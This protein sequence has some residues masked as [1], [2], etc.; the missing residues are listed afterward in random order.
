MPQNEGLSPVNQSEQIKHHLQT[1]LVQI[2]AVNIGKHQDYQPPLATGA[3]GRFTDSPDT[4]QETRNTKQQ[5]ERRDPELEDSSREQQNQPRS[6]QRAEH[7]STHSQAL[8]MFLTGESSHLST[9]LKVQGTERGGSIIGLGFVWECQGIS[10]SPFYLCES[11]KEMIIH[12]KICEHMRSY[13]HQLQYIVSEKWIQNIFKMKVLPPHFNIICMCFQW[14]QHPDFLYFWDYDF[15]LEDMKQDIVEGIAMMLSKQ[16]RYCKVDAQCLLLR[17][18]AF[19]HVKS[20]SFTEALKLVKDLKKDPKLDW[21]TSFTAQQKETRQETEEYHSENTVGYLDGVQQRRVLS[22]L[23][24]KSSSPN[25]DFLVPPIS[26]LSPQEKPGPPDFQHQTPI[27]EYQVKQA[28]VHLESQSSAIVGSK[29]SQ[30]L[31]LSPIDKCPPTRKRPADEPVET[32]DRYS[33]SNPQL[34]DPFPEY[35]KPTCSQ[36]S[37]ESASDSSLVNP[38]ATPPPCLHWTRTQDL[39]LMN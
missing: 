13:D 1:R 36:P 21:Q 10:V 25:A 22:P 15:L 24:V 8:A 28:E 2:P 14:M 39:N 23:N 9:Y 5:Q 29:T 26:S 27:T 38:A 7:V 6:S 19:E 34:E 17:P 30:T 12:Y 11:C 33:S 16:E 32:L 4:C 35:Y 18:G 20:L 31:S 3:A 37:S